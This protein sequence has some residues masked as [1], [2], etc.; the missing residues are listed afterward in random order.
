MIDSGFLEV[1][2]SRRSIRQY[3]NRKID[4]SD[5]C[6]ILEAANWAPS[7]CNAQAWHFI[8]LDEE[9]KI[10]SMVA[11]GLDKAKD[12][13]VLIFVFYRKYIRRKPINL[14]FADYVQSA[15]AAIQNML[16]MAHN[17]GIGACW[18]NGM[19][20]PVNKIIRKPF[21]YEF[22]ALIKLGYSKSKEYKIQ[23]RKYSIE[24]IM[25]YNNF[26]LPRRDILS[27]KEVFWEIL[28]I[29]VKDNPLMK[30]L[31]SLLPSGLFKKNGSGKD[32]ESYKIN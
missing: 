17:L 31:F 26:D 2:K 27:R 9:E 29:K 28:K 3:D 20:I 8:V 6:K 24:E 23:D 32:I 11:K 4:R 14:H 13:P 22:I 25:S 18:I 1:I 21:G 30:L 19:D 12:T 5:I 15:S 16:L 10:N 7:A